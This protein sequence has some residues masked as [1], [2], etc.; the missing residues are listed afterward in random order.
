MICVGYTQFVKL[1]TVI[2]ITAA[3]GLGGLLR[4]YKRTSTT[5]YTP[6]NFLPPGLALFGVS[7]A[8]LVGGQSGGTY[9]QAAAG[10]WGVEKDAEMMTI[11]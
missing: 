4:I 9:F 5:A 6:S 3:E 7:L 2:S 1:C 8:V 11:D 10:R